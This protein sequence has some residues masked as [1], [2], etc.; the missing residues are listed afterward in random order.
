M[1]TT[2]IR[3]GLS[4]GLA[5]ALL[6]CACARREPGMAQLKAGIRQLRKAIAL[7][8]MPPGHAQQNDLSKAAALLEQACA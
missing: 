3:V 6:P 5:L 4:C 1:Q 8:S 7:E 2:R